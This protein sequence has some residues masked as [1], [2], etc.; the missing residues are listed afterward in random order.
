M[1]K[2]YEE[3]ELTAG[4]TVEK[5]VNLLLDYQKKGELVKTKFNGVVLYS[6]TVTMEDA[7]LQIVGRSREEYLAELDDAQR[8]IE[9]ERMDHESRIPELIEEWVAKGNKVLDP[10]RHE[11]W[12]EVVPV[13]LNSM[14]RELALGYS[15]PIIKILNEGR[16][17]D[18]AVTELD[19]QSHSGM[20]RRLVSLMVKDLC[21]Q[22]PDFYERVT[23]KR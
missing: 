15:L 17:I 12:A 11:L 3:I 5:A 7:Y 2:K 20:S 10:D 16:S 1:D 14:Y 18:E 8:R 6:D 13:Q 22:G 19:N 9:K 4:S 21:E 23:L